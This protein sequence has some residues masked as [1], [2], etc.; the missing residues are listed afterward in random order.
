M[1][2]LKIGD[3][4][5]NKKKNV[6][7][8]ILEMKQIILPFEWHSYCISIDPGNK[9]MKVFHNN[10]IQAEQDFTMTHGDKKGITKLMTTGHLGRPKFVGFLTDFQIFGTALT[11]ETLLGWTVCKEQVKFIILR[12]K[13]VFLKSFVSIYSLIVADF[14]IL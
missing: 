14:I 7:K 1:V 11:E 5:S 9:T 4:F 6:F 8:N 2:I 12:Q 3:T 13:I 10:R